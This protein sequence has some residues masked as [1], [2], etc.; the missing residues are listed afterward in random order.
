MKSALALGSTAPPTGC[1]DL[2][3]K[4]GGQSEE[5]SHQRE[6]EGKA[7]KVSGG[8][9]SLN[10]I[11]HQSGFCIY[12]TRSMTRSLGAELTG[13]SFIMMISSPGSSFPSDGPP[14]NIQT[15]ANK[16]QLIKALHESSRQPAKDYLQIK[17]RV[18]TAKLTRR[19][20]VCVIFADVK[21]AANLQILCC[22]C[23]SRH[24]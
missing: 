8:K 24:V 15:H 1:S 5:S 20:S 18:I 14:T 6:R 21:C 10:V 3:F 17:S 4:R 22:L 9:C 7:N 16:Q 23:S 13:S 2:S 12:L 19:M 11:F